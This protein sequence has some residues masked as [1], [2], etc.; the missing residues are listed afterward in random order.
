MYER[1]YIF[2]MAYMSDLTLFRLRSACTIIAFHSAHFV[3]TLNLGVTFELLN[4]QVNEKYCRLRMAT[5]SR[6][7]V[8]GK[9]TSLGWDYIIA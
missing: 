6:D 1:C 4:L 5:Y 7:G 8:K 9:K 2:V 3:V